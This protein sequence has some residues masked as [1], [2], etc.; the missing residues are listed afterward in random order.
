M[1]KPLAFTVA[2]AILYLCPEFGII[3]LSEAPPASKG[4]VIGRARVIDG[5]SLAIGD[6]RIRLYGIDAPEKKQTCHEAEGKTIWLCGQMA[7]NYLRQLID[8]QKI[9]CTVHDIDRYQRKVASC[10]PP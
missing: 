2:L 9:H 8:G 5:D 3:Q 1:R 4:S 7:G 10:H 6:E